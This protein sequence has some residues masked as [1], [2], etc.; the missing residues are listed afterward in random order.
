VVGCVGVLSDRSQVL[1]ADDTASSDEETDGECQDGTEL[2]SLIPDLKL[3]ELRDRQS[4]DNEVEEDVGSTVDIGRQL[5]V[6]AVAFMFAVP[7]VPEEAAT[8]SK[9]LPY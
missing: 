5:E 1:Q 6:A 4:E 3:Q 8:I 9:L 2:P 7:R